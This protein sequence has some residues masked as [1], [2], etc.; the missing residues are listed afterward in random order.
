[1][2]RRQR[3]RQNLNVHIWKV[4]FQETA[5][6]TDYKYHYYQGG[7]YIP[8][9]FSNDQVSDLWEEID[10]ETHRLV[11]IR[12]NRREENLKQYD[13]V[14]FFGYDV[15]NAIAFENVLSGR[16]TDLNAFDRMHFYDSEMDHTNCSCSPCIVKNYLLQAKGKLQE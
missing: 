2:E 12:R 11:S 16:F 3:I 10:P 6:S 1:M 13:K 14:L 4:M 7:V 8:F 5:V 15:I 9:F